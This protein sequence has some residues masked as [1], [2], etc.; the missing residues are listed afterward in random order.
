MVVD[1]RNM[2]SLFVSGLSRL[3]SKE[4]YATMLIGD[5]DMA[6]LMIHVQQCGQVGQF[7]KECP[8][9]R[10]GG[11]NR[12]NRA[13]SSLV[14]PLDRATPRGATSGTSGVEN[15]LYAITSRQ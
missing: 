3:S 12:G 7:M 6:R 2:M 14:A 15:H 13:Q 8:K 1:M 5:I 9:N 11:G 10:Q 4:C